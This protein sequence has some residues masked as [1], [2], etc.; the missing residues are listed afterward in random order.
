MV[1]AARH[2]GFLVTTPLRQALLYGF[3]GH[4]EAQSGLGSPPGSPSTGS[5]SA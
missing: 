1:G 2:P 4:F 5:V 3:G